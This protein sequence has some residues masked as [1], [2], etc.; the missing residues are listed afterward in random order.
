MFDRKN[1]ISLALACMTACFIYFSL[2]LKLIM[3]IRRMDD[4][5]FF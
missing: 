4:D 5:E 1:N 2:M 3:S